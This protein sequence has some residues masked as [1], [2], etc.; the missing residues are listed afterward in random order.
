MEYADLSF[1]QKVIL[2]TLEALPSTS[3]ADRLYF[4][5]FLFVMTK[6]DPA[7]FED[8]NETFEA[9]KAGPYNEYVDEVLQG[10]GD[11][12]LL[13]G[14]EPTL[15]GANLARSLRGDREVAPVV[16]RLAEMADVLRGFSVDDLLYLTY[17]L[18]PEFAVAS[19]IQH[20]IRS[21][22]LESFSIHLA[23]IPDG[24]ELVVGSDK[25]SRIR[26]ARRG[27]AVTITPLP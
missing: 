2:L 4:E 26:V 20:R 10:L 15:E 14:Q 25:G 21:E 17:R 16:H 3:K 23:Q 19:K 1:N 12:G 6:R 7:L 5:K 9:H 27:Q 11:H 8:I 24:G 18:Y 22:T 13:K